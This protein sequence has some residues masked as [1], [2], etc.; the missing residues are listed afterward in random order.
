MRATA[1]RSL[2]GFLGLTL[3]LL[4]SAGAAPRTLRIVEGGQ[5][6]A[7]FQSARQTTHT[8]VRQGKRPRVIV[9]TP[10]G[11]SGIGV[12]FKPLA[13]GAPGLRLASAP[14]E[15]T[16]DGVA[17]MTF[18]VEGPA[19][20]E[21]D[22]VLLDSVRALRAHGHGET[23][24]REAG[25][26]ASLDTIRTAGRGDA[27]VE[28]TIGAAF[29][30][31]APA[32][33]TD[34][35]RPGAVIFERR[36]LGSPA[37]Y[38]LELVP[39]RGT[40]IA[41]EG[42]AMTITGDGAS[43]FTVRTFVDRKPLTPLAKILRTREAAAKKL[44]FLVF[45]EGYLAGSWQYLNYFGRDTMI[46]ARLLGDRLGDEARAAAVEAVLD[47]VSPH[48]EIAHEESL[49]D[50]ATLENLEHL[51]AGI[52]A[53][54]ARARDVVGMDLERP[55]YDYKMI[56]GEYL[57][58]QL[59]ADHVARG[60]TLTAAR[61]AALG[62]VAGR[63]ATQT[64]KFASSG[65]Q[66]DLVEVRAGHHAGNWRDSLAGLGWGRFPLDVNAHLVPSALRA[67]ATLAERPEYA[68][69]LGGSPQVLR[70]RAE[71]WKKAAARFAIV[72]PAAT[73][74]ARLVAYLATLPAAE[75]TIL[76][77]Q[78]LGSGV[79]V[80]DAIAGKAAPE[81]DGG[82]A[83]DAISLDAKGA[84][85]PVLSSDGAFALFYG[86]PS[87]DELLRTVRGVFQPFPIGLVSPVGLMVANPAY[88]DRAGDAALFGKDKYHG[89]V[90]WSWPQTMMT[91]GLRAQLA[92][93][94]GDRE[95]TREV[96]RAL[97]MLG[98]AQKSVAHLGASELWSFRAAADG[99]TLEAVPFGAG[100]NDETEGNALQLW[101]ATR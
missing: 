2:V 57:L 25:L 31:L 87:R 64:E 100:E 30:S 81:L 1:R 70:A 44:G 63:I 51:A 79:T 36:A 42:E 29:A 26:R 96:K 23:A 67:L 14:R 40:T 19:R 16:W 55:V 8:L 72:L 83:F 43:R 56:D 101:S 99:K 24:A 32:R 3:A 45:R 4:A 49:G 13:A 21:I 66:R 74:R 90:V 10:A 77:A 85:V 84:P 80:A 76:G 20:L 17:G 18:D 60:G 93:F 71:A 50:Q 94:K 65:A 98:A 58:P 46:S 15:T 47:R 9:A 68:K 97:A 73:A 33:V 86:E 22:R 38:R 95:V 52:K 62:R 54:T 28:A 59:V 78:R 91:R 53:G 11:N 7:L 88:S 92:R 34:P 37:R 69:T 89:T 61:V 12:W 48:G 41:G 75:R 27:E 5:Q 35:A 39:R 6:Q 82:V